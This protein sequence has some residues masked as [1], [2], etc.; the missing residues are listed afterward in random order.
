MNICLSLLQPRQ[1][2][3]GAF[4]FVDKSNL[5][6]NCNTFFSTFLTNIIIF[7][8]NLIFVRLLS[9]PGSIMLEL[10][11]VQLTI[12]RYN[13]NVF[14]LARTTAETILA[15]TSHLPTQHAVKV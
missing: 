4:I 15:S 7:E 10:V 9:T 13:T 12:A 2:N 8:T 1:R 3:A 5:K 11:T 14:E 6:K